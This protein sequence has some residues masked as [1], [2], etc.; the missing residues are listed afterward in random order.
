VRQ[1]AC[2]LDPAETEKIRAGFCGNLINSMRSR[3]SIFTAVISISIV[4]RR[5]DVA[6][7]PAAHP[8]TAP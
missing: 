1:R 6:D 2:Q 3:G 5:Q 7:E 4:D 8:W